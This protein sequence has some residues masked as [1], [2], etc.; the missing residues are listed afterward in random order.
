MNAAEKNAAERR[1]QDV[2]IEATFAS[3]GAELRRAN[4][5]TAGEVMR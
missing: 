5:V 1:R 3:P 4:D 2:S